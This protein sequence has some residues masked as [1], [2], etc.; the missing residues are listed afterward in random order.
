LYVKDIVRVIVAGNSITKQTLP[1]QDA[2]APVDKDAQKKLVAPLKQLDISLAELAS[3]I[4]VDLMA[5]A[6]DPVTTTLPQQPI[7]DCLFPHASRCESTFKKVTNP[8]E[9]T[10]G[11]AEVTFLGHSGQPIEDL[12]KYTKGKSP[13]ELM[14]DTLKWR[15]VAPTA[16]DTLPCFPFTEFDPFILDKAQ[17]HVYFCGNQNDFVSKLTKID[18]P[19]GPVETRIVLVPKFSETG[20]VVLVDINS[21]TLECSTLSFDA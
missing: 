11:D 14:E 16:P 3:A 15:H 18:T 19:N 20:L 21:P 6:S 1:T 13:I 5:G 12:L 2:S 9:F 8:H 7:H 17:P 4:P 10:T